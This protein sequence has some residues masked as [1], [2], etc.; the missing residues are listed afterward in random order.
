MNAYWIWTPK[1]NKQ[2]VSK[3]I[4]RDIFSTL[5]T[6]VWN[7][8]WLIDW[9]DMGWFTNYVCKSRWVGGLI[10]HLTSLFGEDPLIGKLSVKWKP[11][12][13]WL[14]WED[15]CWVLC[16]DGIKLQS[17]HCVRFWTSLVRNCPKHPA[18]S[19]RTCGCGTL[20]IDLASSR[21]PSWH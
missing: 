7:Q 8:I 11:F 14:L 12:V 13:Q 2:R 4:D 20:A 18:I 9:F 3:Y 17:L 6:Y 1:D 21:S 19:N 10:H 15:K 16:A 5:F